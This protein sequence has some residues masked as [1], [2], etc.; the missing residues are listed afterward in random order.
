MILPIVLL[1]VGLGLIVAEIFLPSFGI[2]SVLAGGSIVAALVFAFRHDT[3]TGF[4]FFLSTAALVPLTIGL[5]FGLL[6][7]TA[8]GRRLILSG[9]GGDHGPASESKD[10]LVGAEGV[11]ESPLRP[12]GF[13][14]I[15][16]RRMD[17]STR[18][19]WL[20]VGVHVRVVDVRDNRLIV[21]EAP[22]GAPTEPPES[23]S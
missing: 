5:A 2:L 11:V 8:F 16:G 13:A 22:S 23:H 9:G 12:S 14:R 1:G 10:R 21:S 17:V 3:Q 19:D 15:E 20:D 7:K 6:P 18:G 4:W